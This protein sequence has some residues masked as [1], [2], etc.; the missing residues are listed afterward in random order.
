MDAEQR[1]V[2]N[3]A[4]MKRKRRAQDA[5]IIVFHRLALRHDKAYHARWAAW[6]RWRYKRRLKS[7]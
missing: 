4:W 6:L 7:G 1:R 2:Y 3:A 5:A